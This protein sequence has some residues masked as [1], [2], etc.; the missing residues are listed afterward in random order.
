MQAS[1]TRAREADDHCFDLSV[2]AIVVVVGA[3]VVV[4]GA[5]VVV[6]GGSRGSSEHPSPM[7]RSASTIHTFTPPP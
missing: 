1:T 3:I 6:G 7:A 5:I 4:V 2:R